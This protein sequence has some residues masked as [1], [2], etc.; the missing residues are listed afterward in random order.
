MRSI[1]CLF[2][3]LAACA[4]FPQL[5]DRISDAAREA[6][7]PTLSQLP[8]IPPASSTEEATLLAR[9][10]ILQARAAQ[11]RLIEIGALQ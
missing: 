4:S 9:I 7:F 5:D 8:A 10:E 6:P 2:L 11:I 1:I 3:A